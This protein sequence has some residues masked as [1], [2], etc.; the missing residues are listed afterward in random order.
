MKVSI[1]KTYCP[2]CRRLVR[3]IETKNNNGVNVTC[4]LCGRLLWVWDGL[5]MKSGKKTA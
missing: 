2:S 3:G 4:S 1:K 5:F